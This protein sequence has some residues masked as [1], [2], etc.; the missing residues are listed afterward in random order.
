MQIRRQR[1]LNMS[2][3]RIKQRSGKYNNQTKV[4]I[5]RN[6]STRHI[7]FPQAAEIILHPILFPHL[8]DETR[9]SRVN[10]APTPTPGTNLLFESCEGKKQ[11]A[12]GEY[13]KG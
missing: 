12:V 4:V 2:V 11:K 6:F 7:P 10:K 8:D 5:A 3:S 13:I 1:V 9:K